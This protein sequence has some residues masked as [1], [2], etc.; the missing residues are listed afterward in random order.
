MKDIRGLQR[1]P[2]AVAGWG[3]S[4]R[5]PPERIE[6]FHWHWGMLKRISLIAVVGLIF[7]IVGSLIAI[8]IFGLTHDEGSWAFVLIGYITGGIIGNKLYDQGVG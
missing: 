6:G 7:G 2:V 1:I 5:K 3:P 4:I 8:F